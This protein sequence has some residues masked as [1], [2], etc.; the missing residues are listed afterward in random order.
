V[1]EWGTMNKTEQKDYIKNQWNISSGKRI[2]EMLRRYWLKENDNTNTQ[3]VP[4]DLLETA[5]KIFVE[6]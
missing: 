6:G 4:E 3:E 5:K 1:G 2:S